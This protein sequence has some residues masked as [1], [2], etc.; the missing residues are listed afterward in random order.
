MPYGTD[1]YTYSEWLEARERYYEEQERRFEEAREE[2]LIREM[3]GREEKAIRIIQDI[4]SILE[5]KRKK[6]YVLGGEE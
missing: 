6:S 2:E 1:E 5:G 3:E 4:I